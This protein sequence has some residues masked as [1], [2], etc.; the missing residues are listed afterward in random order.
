MEWSGGMNARDHGYS[1]STECTDLLHLIGDFGLPKWAGDK[2]S[3]PA[4]I[5]H[6]PVQLPYRGLRRTMVVQTES[7]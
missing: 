1:S 7:E 5:E 4:R 3:I 2:A 6:K